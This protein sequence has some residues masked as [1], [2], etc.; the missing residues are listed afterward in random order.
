MRQRDVRQASVPFDVVR[1]IRF[2]HDFKI[3]L[4]KVG[5]SRMQHS[6]YTSN[7]KFAVALV[8]RNVSSLNDTVVD[9]VSLDCL[10]NRYHR[11][12]DREDNGVGEMKVFKYIAPGTRPGDL[13]DSLSGLAGSHSIES[14]IGRHPTITEAT[15]RVRLLVKSAEALKRPQDGNDSS[16][17][18]KHYIKTIMRALKKIVSPGG[19]E[20]DE[21]DTIKVLNVYFSDDGGGE[22]GKRW[23]LVEESKTPN[24]FKLM[25]YIFNIGVLKKGGGSITKFDPDMHKRAMDLIQ[26]YMRTSGNISALDMSLIVLHNQPNLLTISDPEYAMSYGFLYPTVG[27]QYLFGGSQ[28]RSK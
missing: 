2:G 16:S 20:M 13:K 4:P 15:E 5:Q 12:V 14:S 24:Y 11:F 8:C 9:N 27:F 1:A 19:A 23:I 18:Y 10:H 21:W 3:H 6:N 22:I 25:N 17:I 26:F 7:C 28:H